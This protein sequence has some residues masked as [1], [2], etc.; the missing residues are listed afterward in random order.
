VLPQVQYLALQ[1]PL[2]VPAQQADAQ[3]SPLHAEF[4]D[5]L[6]NLTALIL[7]VVTIFT[8]PFVSTATLTAPFTC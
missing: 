5:N 3:Y 2:V 4:E 1:Y 7:L 6:I 8:F